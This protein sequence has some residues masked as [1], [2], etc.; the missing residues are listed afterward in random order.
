M[1]LLQPLQK[2]LLIKTFFLNP[3]FLGPILTVT[4][5]GIQIFLELSSA[6]K[7]GSYPCLAP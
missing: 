5:N 1:F 6:D 4:F 2:T 7:I 3:K